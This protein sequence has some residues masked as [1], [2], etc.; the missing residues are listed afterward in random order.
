V[1]RLPDIQL[2]A[3]PACAKLYKRKVDVWI[4]MRDP[5]PPS[6]P[7]SDIPRICVCG[8]SFLLAEST[9]VANLPISQR[10]RS[11]VLD[12]FGMDQLDI[13]A[14]LRKREDSD[15]LLPVVKRSVSKK[16]KLLR[17]FGQWLSELFQTLAERFK[18]PEK[19]TKK[20]LV[21]SVLWDMEAIALPE[22][23][24]QSPAHPNQIASTGK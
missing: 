19:R 21:Q 7:P 17:A 14:F 11:D 10:K 8:R 5:R 12:E 22:K 3:C 2:F 16:K 1:A 20:D 18:K 13:P 4:D 15:D 6:S 24:A 9:I 23:I